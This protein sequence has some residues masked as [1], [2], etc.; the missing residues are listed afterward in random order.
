MRMPINPY[1]TG[2]F[3]DAGK[4]TDIQQHYRHPATLQTS[5][6]TTGTRQTYIE[7]ATGS[8]RN[9]QTTCFQTDNLRVSCYNLISSSNSISGSIYII[10]SFITLSQ[11]I[12]TFLLLTGTC[13][14]P[15]VGSGHG[16]RML[17]ND[18]I[19]GCSASAASAPRHVLLL[20]WHGQRQ[21]LPDALQFLPEVSHGC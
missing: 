20:L 17:W 21:S 6:N 11:H 1:N 3:T 12:S 14:L 10:S 15:S 8:S 13:W 18:S 5:G 4:P 9:P 2:K 7:P 16:I 19:P